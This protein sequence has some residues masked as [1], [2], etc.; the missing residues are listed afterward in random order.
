MGTVRVGAYDG[1]GTARVG[2]FRPERLTSAEHLTHTVLAEQLSLT[3]NYSEA[4][5]STP[6]LRMLVPETAGRI[7]VNICDIVLFCL[8]RE[9]K[10]AK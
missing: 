4:S 10:Y 3:E 7:F 6:V 5:T 9:R 8:R 2:G 1:M